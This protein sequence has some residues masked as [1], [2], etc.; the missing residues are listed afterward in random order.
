MKLNGLLADRMLLIIFFLSSGCICSGCY[1]PVCVLFW[2]SLGSGVLVRGYGVV[3][4]SAVVVG[5]VAAV[6]VGI[7]VVEGVGEVKFSSSG[8]D[9][10]LIGVNDISLVLLSISL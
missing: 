1:A 7:W 4:V 10:L 6:L 2:I 8:V 5:D 3:A 9:L